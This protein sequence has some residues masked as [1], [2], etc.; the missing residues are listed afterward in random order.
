MPYRSAFRVSPELV[1]RGDDGSLAIYFVETIGAWTR[2][3][4]VPV[5]SLTESEV[6]KTVQT[7]LTEIV[8][9]LGPQL[10]RA[11]RDAQGPGAAAPPAGETVQ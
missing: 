9:E 5:E 11:I 4:E 1:R 7:L 2:C 8:Q 10:H 6:V 3:V